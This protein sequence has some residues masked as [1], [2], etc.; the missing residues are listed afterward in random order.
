MFSSGWGDGV[1]SSWWG[2][3]PAGNLVEVVTDFQVLVETTSEK[4]DL[5]LPLSRGRISHPVLEKH[6]VRM[7]TPLLS[8]SAVILAGTDAARVELS[9]GAPVTMTYRGD[10]RHYTWATSQPGTRLIVSVMTGVKPLDLA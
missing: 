4:F 5:P 8:R 2:L 3:G 1:Y 6:D 7:K 9:D 10:E